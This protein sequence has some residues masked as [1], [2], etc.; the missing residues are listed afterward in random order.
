MEVA[1]DAVFNLDMH[2]LKIIN[3]L[4]HFGL[5]PN[6]EPLPTTTP[7]EAM[8]LKTRTPHDKLQYIETF[9]AYNILSFF[10]RPF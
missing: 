1:I 8:Q 3:L 4:T 2:D 7:P 6:Q 9:V 10:F 5:N